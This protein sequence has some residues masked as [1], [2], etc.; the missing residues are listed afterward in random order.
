MSCAETIKKVVEV[1]RADDDRKFVVVSAP[2]KRF[3]DDIKITDTLYSCFYEREE[4]GLELF[5]VVCN[6]FY[7]LVKELKL[8]L[9]ISPVIEFYRKKIFSCDKADE[10]VS[11]GE[12]LS[13][14]IL[15]NY[16]K[17]DFIDARAIIKFDSK[18]EFNSEYTNDVVKN[19][20]KL[21]DKAVISGFYGQD[22]KGNTV[23]FSR[24]GSDVTGSIIARAVKADVYE[25]WTDVSG[26]FVAD[27][28][29]VENPKVIKYLSY[30]ELRELSYMGASVIHPDSVFPVR[31]AKIPI[32]IR[33]T[34]DP[35]K[36]GTMI[37][38]EVYEHE[39]LVTGIA[40]KKDFT[41]ILIEKDKMNNEVGFARKLLSILE[42]YNVSFEHLP[43]GIDTMTVVISDSEL[44]GRMQ[45]LL[46][47]IRNAVSPD[48][49][50]I[51]ENLALIATVGHGMSFK[52][53]TAARLFSA[54]SRYGINIRMIDQG[55]SELNIIVA[56]SNDDYEKAVN[57][58]YEEFIN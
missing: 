58:I 43:S 5:N 55:S 50:E 40:G 33:N 47:D 4:R 45:E 29:I 8:E 41:S 34:F 39:R 32:N 13:A 12:H 25:N 21:H 20:L 14:Y 6:R 23:V 48:N 42:H 10:I 56:V 2:G 57:A 37:L 31:K 3:K 11:M 17:W 7:D 44:G 15:A 16:L 49:I 27:P 26:C 46:W 19:E 38:P 30:K 36:E 1:L 35:Q 28:R 22:A 51:Q 52:P 18:G 9:D 54:L 53:G 24:G